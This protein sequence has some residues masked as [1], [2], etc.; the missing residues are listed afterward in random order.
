MM[1]FPNCRAVEIAIDGIDRPSI[2]DEQ[3]KD[4]KTSLSCL[5]SF[6]FG[7]GFF[8]YRKLHPSPRDYG[9]NAKALPSGTCE[10]K[11][12]MY[13]WEEILSSR[14]LHLFL[15]FLDRRNKANMARAPA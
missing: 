14:A 5:S 15:A 12:Q 10:I 11:L 7:R 6:I 4:I 9:F 1:K 8:W 2:Y 13:F 3:T